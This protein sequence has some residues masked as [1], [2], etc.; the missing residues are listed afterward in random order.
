M[1]RNSIWKVPV[2]AVLV[3]LAGWTWALAQTQEFSADQIMLGPEGEQQGKIYF[4]QDRWQIEMTQTQ[5]QK[6]IVQPSLKRTKARGPVQRD[7]KEVLA[8]VLGNFM[9]R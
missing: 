3:I 2:L 9:P 1:K 4:K 5:M 6:A 7:A 8:E